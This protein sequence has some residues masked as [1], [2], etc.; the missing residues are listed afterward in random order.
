MMNMAKLG[1]VSQVAKLFESTGNPMNTGLRAIHYAY[2]GLF[3]MAAWPLFGLLFLLV[4][5]IKEPCH[6]PTDV[7][8]DFGLSLS[9]ACARSTI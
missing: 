5:M 7:T 2:L 1:T 4:S 9:S 6:L 3:Q 8:I